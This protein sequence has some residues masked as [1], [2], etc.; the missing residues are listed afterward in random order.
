MLTEGFTDDVVVFQRGERECDQR[1]CRDQS[2]SR[3]AAQ[4][5]PSV[6]PTVLITRGWLVGWLVG[7]Q[8]TNKKRADNR[9]RIAD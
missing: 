9:L 3:Q 5:N 1:H 7:W 4:Q 6:H 8:E 2:Y